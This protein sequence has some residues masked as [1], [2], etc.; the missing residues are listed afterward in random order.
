MHQRLDSP[1]SWL[2]VWLIIWLLSQCDYE[3]SL[4]I[5]NKYLIF[6]RLK[7]INLLTDN[8][9]IN[10]ENLSP[11]RLFVVFGK[12]LAAGFRN[13][14]LEAIG[15]GYRG[16]GGRWSLRAAGTVQ[17]CWEDA[18][19]LLLE[20]RGGSTSV[21]HVTKLLEESRKYPVS[22]PRKSFKNWSQSSCQAKRNKVSVHNIEN[23]R[24]C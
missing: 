23:K 4:L 18:V 17:R 5:N 9:R 10:W 14:S 20:T 8:L 16:G 15:R 19:H 12:V 24:T 7:V 22:P 3:Y 1:V 6:W 11:N 21:C 13:W 2:H